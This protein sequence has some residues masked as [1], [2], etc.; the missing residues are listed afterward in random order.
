MRLQ[1]RAANLANEFAFGETHMVRIIQTICGLAFFGLNGFAIQQAYI[2]GYN[3]FTGETTFEHGSDLSSGPGSVS[4]VP[5]GALYP[6]MNIRDYCK[7]SAKSGNRTNWNLVNMCVERQRKAKR[8][9]ERLQVSDQARARCTR[10]SRNG[11]MV[12]NRCVKSAARRQAR[13]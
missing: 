2:G 11:Y 13:R 10:R 7:A 6:T 9:S 12:Y 5:P 4:N 8:E 1:T 3:V